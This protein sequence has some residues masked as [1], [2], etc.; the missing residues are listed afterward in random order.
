MNNNLRI[1]FMGTP[2]F[3]VA[4]LDKLVKSNYNIVAVVTSP[5]KPAG[6]GRKIMRSAVKEYALENNLNVLQPTNLKDENFIK[7]LRDLNIELQIVV[8]F[9][10]LPEI[11]WK[12]PEYGT[13]NLHASLLPQYRGAAPINRAI[14]NG[15]SETGVTS[16]FINESIDTGNIIMNEKVMIKEDENAGELHDRLMVIGGE[17][18]VKTVDLIENK[19]LTTTMQSA[20]INDMCNLQNA[21][22]IFKNDCKINWSNSQQEVYNFIR[23]LSPY[24][25]AFTELISPDNKLITLK[26]FRTVKIDNVNSGDGII[27]TDSVNYL[28][29]R[30]KNGSLSIKELQLSGKKKMGISD[31]LRGFEIKNCWKIKGY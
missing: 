4:S 13:F 20:L 29:I 22:K 28:N 14:M 10:M 21:P 17:L 3:A 15:E 18:V 30:C 7:E 11:V 2:D 19:K 12:M 25:A 24:P 8:A 5:D 1:A 27:D 16:F 23:G 6:R 9:R 26:I 31:F